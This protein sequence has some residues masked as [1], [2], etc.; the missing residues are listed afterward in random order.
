MS[1]KIYVTLDVKVELG[2]RISV[3]EILE[4]DAYDE[5]DVVVKAG[6]VDVE[7]QLQPGEAELVKLLLVKA[8]QAGLTYKLTDE[9][10]APSMPLD[11]P[12]FLLGDG[13]I[14]LL[15]AAPQKL[16]FS[17]DLAVDVTVHALVGREVT[18]SP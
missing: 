15:D 9:T 14:G 13:G 16:F 3:A 1:Q 18:P 10:S 4:L 8:D 11:K 7:V 2:P 5:I 17:N 6:D 12:L